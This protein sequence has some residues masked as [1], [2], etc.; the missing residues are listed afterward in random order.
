M[1]LG[2]PIEECY[3]PDCR[4]LLIDYTRQLRRQHPPEERGFASDYLLLLSAW[5]VHETQA[6]FDAFIKE[7]SER[8]RRLEKA[9]EPTDDAVRAS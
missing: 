8:S 4:G 1:P 5:Y 7:F 3:C 2:R 9:A 6:E